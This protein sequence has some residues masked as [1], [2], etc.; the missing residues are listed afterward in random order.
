MA[1]IALVSTNSTYAFTS[2]RAQNENE[3]RFYQHSDS[4]KVGTTLAHLTQ[5][6]KQHH[7]KLLPN[8]F[9]LNS[10]TLEFHTAIPI[11]VVGQKFKAASQNS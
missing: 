1:L 6:P 4:S 8:S 3:K 7:R 9:Y 5:H 10:H 11:N 2:K